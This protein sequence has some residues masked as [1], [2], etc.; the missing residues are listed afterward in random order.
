MRIALFSAIF[1]VLSA[2][3]ANADTRAVEDK[4]LDRFEQF[5]GAP[6]DG[7]DMWQMYQWQSLGPDRLA[8]WS[9]INKV[10]LL[11]VAQPCVRLEDAKG[12]AVT[13]QMMHKVTRRLDY[14]EFGTQHCQIVE[15]RPV[16]YK[17]MVR[18]GDAAKTRN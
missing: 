15:I 3:Y 12:I 16:D 1:V 7:F 10:W 4:N 14:V 5:A 17:A 2:Q 8:V 11:K 6:I 9:A 13:S 18:V